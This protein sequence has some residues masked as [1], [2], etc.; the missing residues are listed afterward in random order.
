MLTKQEFRYISTYECSKANEIP[1]FSFAGLSTLCRVTK[2]V[3]GDTCDLVLW[4]RGQI[5]RLRVRVNGIDT[6]EKRPRGDSPTKELEKQCGYIVRDILISH[7]GNRMCYVDIHDN[8]K[9]GRPL[10]TLYTLP[11]DKTDE[12]LYSI[13]KKNAYDM[14]QKYSVGEWL[15][16]NGYAHAYDGGTKS[17]WTENELI[18][19]RDNMSS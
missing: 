10:V 18:R 3:D 16:S 19:I 9:Y 17:E 14:P 7:I 11:S 12:E 2:V 13:W 15:I 4:Y 8:D 6:P 5:L 1:Y